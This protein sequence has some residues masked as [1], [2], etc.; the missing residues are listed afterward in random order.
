MENIEKFQKEESLLFD[1]MVETARE[2]GSTITTNGV[3]IEG[4]K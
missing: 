1:E 3:I 2:S 4:G